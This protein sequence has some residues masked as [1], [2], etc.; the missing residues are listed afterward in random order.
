MVLQGRTLATASTYLAVI[1]AN[2]PLDS[3]PD[4]AQQP[5]IRSSM[6]RRGRDHGHLRRQAASL[7]AKALAAV[8][9]TAPVVRDH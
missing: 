4:P 6:K 9:A 1:A 7:I 3:Q 5:L 8:R 2:Y